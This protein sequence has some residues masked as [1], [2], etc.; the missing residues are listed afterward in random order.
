MRSAESWV[1]TKFVERRGTWRPSTVE[2]VPGSQLIAHRQVRAYTDALREHATG[3]L[4][5]LGCGSVPLYGAYRGLV[6]ST[7][8][9]DWPSTLHPSPHLDHEVDLGQPLP[10]PDRSYDTVLLTDVLE[11][12]PYPD[13]LWGEL[14][15]VLRPGGT[16]IVGVPFMYWLHEQPHDHHRYTEFRLRLFAA[17]HGFDVAHLAS[18]GDAVDV[19]VDIIGKSLGRTPVRGLAGPLQRLAA[20]RRPRPAGP[21][22]L[23]YLMVA[24]SRGR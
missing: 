5:D 8:C 24:T 3:D 18:Y 12:L 20:R 13:R 21:M 6:R 10:L 14:A 9:A 23:G 19:L 1:P 2:V 22:P 15:R 17:D 4:L 11:H 7:T 16:V